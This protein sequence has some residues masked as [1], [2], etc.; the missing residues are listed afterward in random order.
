MPSPAVNPNISVLIQHTL[1]P[2]DGYKFTN[3]LYTHV[4]NHP[5]ASALV[6]PHPSQLLLS[7]PESSTAP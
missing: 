5:R 3:V 6:Y 4:Q 1:V 7:F 2:L